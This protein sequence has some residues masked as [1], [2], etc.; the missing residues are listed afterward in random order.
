MKLPDKN[1]TIISGHYGTGKTEFAVNLALAMARAGY[2][3][4]IVDLD[5]VNPYF[6]SHERRRELEREGIIVHVTSHQGKA[7][8]PSLAP[9]IMSVFVDP[10]LR[11]V[12][13]LGGDPVGARVLGYYKPELDQTPYDFWFMINRNR[14]E[15]KSIDK[16]IASLEATQALSRQKITG[17]INSTH[18]GRETR[19]TD[20]LEG[21]AYAAD[22]AV[23]LGLPLI[24][25][26]G[27]RKFEKAL[28]G[29]LKGSFFPIDLY[30]IKP[31]E[32]SE[33]EGGHFEWLVE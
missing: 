25:T 1:I 27:E 22:I 30:M 3:T 9:G 6:R 23:R 32:L 14:P 28:E 18:L 15:N 11:S 20:I 4:A 31:W 17:I 16:V 26:V 12:I 7:D 10:E 19:I 13:D 5:I 29:R 21:D 8:I 33:A 24:Y 2:K